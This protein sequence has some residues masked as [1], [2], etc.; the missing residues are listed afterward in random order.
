[1]SERI[2]LK[3]AINF[4]HCFIL[5]LV[6]Y[7]VTHRA[8]KCHKFPTSFHFKVGE[9]WSQ[10][11]WRKNAINFQHCFILKSVKYVGTHT[12]KKCKKFPTL[13]HFKVG[14]ICRNAYDEKMQ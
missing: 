13:F 7:V 14:E 10:R 4:Q 1:M 3:N 8:K 2:W 12:A 6:K 5:K 9:I 11:I